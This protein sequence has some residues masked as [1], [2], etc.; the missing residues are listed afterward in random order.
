MSQIQNST[1]LYSP[2]T[3]I[4]DDAGTTPFVTIAAGITAA[5][6]L[7]YDTTIFVRTGTYTENLT[8]VEGINIQGE[9]KASTIIIGTHIIPAT[10]TITLSNLTL[11]ATGT[12]S[13]F[14]EAAAGTCI[15][16][17]DNCVFNVN[18]GMIFDL[19][20][21]TGDL[22]IYN[23]NDLSTANS[24]IDNSTGKSHLD[25]TNSKIGI[26][27]T[28]AIMA[29]H[30]E[31]INSVI[32]APL[33]LESTNITAAINSTFYADIVLGDTAYLNAN[34]CTI[35][36]GAVAALNIGATATATLGNIVIDCSVPAIIGAGTCT[37][38]EVTFLDN[39][40]I[41]I[42]TAVYTTQVSTGTLKARSSITSA[43][44]DI[45]AITGNIVATLGDVV[46]TNGKLTMQG[47]D[48]TDGQVLIG[49]TATGKPAWASLSA[50]TGIS[51]T[52]GANSLTITST[53]TGGFTWAPIAV[54]G[55]FTNGS[56]VIVN[57]AGL[58]TMTL[59][60]TA[61]VGTVIA[62][63]GTA[64]GAGGWAI[65]QNAGQNIWLQGTSTTIGVGGSLASSLPSD[66]V[67]L[68]CTVADTTWNSIA[69][70]GNIIFV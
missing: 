37:I 54:N 10:D 41:S 50:G 69:V 58:L 1:Y 34:N 48:G 33:S 67:T 38:G 53:A 45:T 42:T 13:I 57:K 61:A 49:D 47:A 2:N 23:C 60:A 12:N 19:V 25:I 46:V 9:D 70:G 68:L 55:S 3:I 65:A 6:G 30:T 17:L 62:I 20:T 7:G 22:A 52:P 39:T 21:S 16:E 36:S 5:V 56:G 11:Q 35:A 66:G 64:F 51:F 8:L 4:V 40:I 14:T 59:P 26:G 29:G 18:D 43:L 27:A 24:I 44:G 28:A 32:G 15:I 31:I 63:Q